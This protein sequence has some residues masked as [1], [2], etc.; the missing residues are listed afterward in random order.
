MESPACEHCSRAPH[1]RFVAESSISA[2]S[3]A[4]LARRISGASVLA[5]DAEQELCGRFAR[6]IR[7]YGLRHLG[8]ESEADDLVQRV[9]L[10]VLTKLR[11]GQVRELEQIASFVLGSARLT[12]KEMRRHRARQVVL[13]EDE[14]APEPVVLAVEP[15]D[16]GRLIGCLQRLAERERSVIVRSFFEGAT[17]SEIAM[18]LGLESGHVRVVRHRALVS[19]R[20]CLEVGEKGAA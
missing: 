11:S 2:I 6:R 4:E 5:P 18:P 10:L 13:P 1:W 8:S 3:D 16:R 19:L 7:A 9:L 15:L 17:A 20:V 14:P 12:A